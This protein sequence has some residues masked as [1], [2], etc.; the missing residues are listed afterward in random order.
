MAWNNYSD[1]IMSAMASNHWHLNCL[2]DRLFRHRS[3]KTSK[4]HWPLWG[5]STSDQWPSQRASSV[6]NV[7]IWWH[8]DV[9]MWVS[10]LCHHWFKLGG[11]LMISPRFSGFPPKGP[12]SSAERASMSWR[13]HEA[14]ICWCGML[15][16]FW[17][18]ITSVQPWPAACVWLMLISMIY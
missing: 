18:S 8:H 3:K 14:P 12:A 7:S 5:E 15:D 6:E 13:H 17:L 10:E 2:L 1:D 4:L 9:I 11:G 16:G